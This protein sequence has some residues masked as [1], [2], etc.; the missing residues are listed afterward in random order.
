MAET[1]WCKKMSEKEI[2]EKVENEQIQE[3]KV[4]VF[5]FQ[6]IDGFE[7]LS[8]VLI[9]D[10][11]NI[12]QTGIKRKINGV[13]MYYLFYSDKSYLKLW[14]DSKNNLLYFI[15]NYYGSLFMKNEPEIWKFNIICPEF[16]WNNDS[17]TFNNVKLKFDFP[18]FNAVRQLNLTL[19][20]PVAYI[21]YKLYS[22]NP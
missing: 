5:Y 21:V 20:T 13:N 4:R 1:P 3:K 7:R 22:R 17:L 15:D 11:K 9:I 19:A 6:H 8:P 2:D 10:G 16:E 12:W 14:R 18:I